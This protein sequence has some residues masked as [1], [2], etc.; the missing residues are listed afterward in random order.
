M[1]GWCEH[2]NELGDLVK[3]GELLYQAR[4]CCCLLKESAPRSGLISHSVRQSA[5][6]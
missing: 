1:A 3:C 5:S 4:N 6:S 2:G